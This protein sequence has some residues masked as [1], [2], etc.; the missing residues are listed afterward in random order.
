MPPRK[1][2]TPP[3]VTVEGFEPFAMVPRWLYQHPDVTDGAIRAWIALWDIADRDTSSAIVRRRHL[4]KAMRCHPST[5]D[6]RLETLAEIG[7]L[8]IVERVD[9]A[10]QAANLYTL[11]WTRKMQHPL[12]TSDEG[13]LATSDDPPSPPVTTPVLQEPLLQEP[14]FEQELAPAIAARTPNPW[15]DAMAFVFGYQPA[16]AEAAIWGRFTTELRTQNVNPAEIPIRA[17]RLVQQ[18]GPK[19]LTVTSLEKWWHRFGTPL[20]AASTDEADAFVE[21]EVRRR[22]LTELEAVEAA[23]DKT[24]THE[25]TSIG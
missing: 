20:G 25:R 12:S 4:A 3:P 5:V 19:A 22:R 14:P 2:T 6:R 16:K 1:P 15:W 21:A 11:H 24:E 23:L 7:A 10:G 8:A 9:G 17:G 13:A 18:W